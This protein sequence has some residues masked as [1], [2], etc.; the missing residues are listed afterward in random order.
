MSSSSVGSSIIEATS[1]MPATKSRVLLSTCRH[2]DYMFT[3]IMRRHNWERR[4]T[5]RGS[6]SPDQLRSADCRMRCWQTKGLLSVNPETLYFYCGYH[7]PTNAP[8]SP[9]CRSVPILDNL[10][11]SNSE[12]TNRSQNADGKCS[13][14]DKVT[15]THFKVTVTR[16]RSTVT[17]FAA[18]TT[19]K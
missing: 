17:R 8:R 4:L 1:A 6:G 7:P 18:V 13:G 14:F 19:L 11:H 9:V 16:S 12:G 15:V 3:G 10:S 2:D 5:V